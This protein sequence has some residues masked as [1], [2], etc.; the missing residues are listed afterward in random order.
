[1]SIDCAVKV[2]RAGLITVTKSEDALLSLNSGLKAP[3]Y[4]VRGVGVPPHPLT[5]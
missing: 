2:P 4:R 5:T 1:M 3:I